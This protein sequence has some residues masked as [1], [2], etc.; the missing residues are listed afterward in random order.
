MNPKS[1]NP[2]PPDELRDFIDAHRVHFDDEVPPAHVWEGI[3]QTFPPRQAKVR[4]LHPY[5][6]KA[7]VAAMLLTIGLLGGLL[8]AGER[9][10]VT[11]ADATI[12]DRAA[13][14]ERYYQREIDRRLQLVASYEPEPELRRELAGMSQLEFRSD[15]EFAAPGSGNQRAVL[16]AMAQEYQAKLDALEHVLE[17]LREAEQYHININVP[18]PRSQEEL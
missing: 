9:A 15:E 17:Q 10:K 16:E 12:A 7:A 13:E 2:N 5:W 3:E 4:R 14:V 6:R 1:H 11:Q 18:G 8:L